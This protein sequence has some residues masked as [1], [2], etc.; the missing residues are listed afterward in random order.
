MALASRNTAPVSY[1]QDVE[2]EL[3]VRINGTLP[4]LSVRGALKPS[5]YAF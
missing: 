1:T 2:I 5:A 4:D 3:L